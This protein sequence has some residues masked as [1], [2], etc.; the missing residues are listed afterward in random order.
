MKHISIPEM[1]QMD[2]N[3][4]IANAKIAEFENQAYRAGHMVRM[5]LL[6]R[7]DAADLLYEAAIYNGLIFEYGQDRIQQIMAEGIGG[8]N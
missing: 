7:A 3:V 6:R 4:A 1:L 2:F 8:A 5:G